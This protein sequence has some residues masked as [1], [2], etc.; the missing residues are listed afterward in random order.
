MNKENFIKI[1]G[2]IGSKPELK[3]M[4]DKVITSFS[5]AQ[6]ERK[7]GD[8]GN[9]Y[10]SHTNWVD[11]ACSHN[12][13]KRSCEL[14]KGERVTV[15]GSLRTITYQDK[16]GNTRK[17][18]TVWADSIERST[19]LLKSNVAIGLRKISETINVMEIEN[20]SSNTPF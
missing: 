5:I 18:Y 9:Y 4:N 3:E 19:P 10:D 16:E 1:T 8:D 12:L 14:E 6:N 20:E 17:S 15:I 7:K 13:A 2:N 11:I